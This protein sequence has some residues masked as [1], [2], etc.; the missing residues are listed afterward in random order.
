MTITLLVAIYV[1]GMLIT[2][3][4]AS[5][6]QE[7]GF[8]VKLIYVVLWPIVLLGNILGGNHNGQ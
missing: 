7:A 1:A 5:R 8:I 4:V 6:H 2:S 3:M